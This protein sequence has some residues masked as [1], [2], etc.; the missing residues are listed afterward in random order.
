MKKLYLF[1]RIIKRSCSSFVEDN[2][3]KLSAALSY[4]TVFSIGPILLIIISLAGVFFGKEAVEGKIYHQIKG[5]VGS[6]AALQ[7]QNIIQ[8]ISQTG[9]VSGGAVIGG[10]ILILTAT[11]VFT[12]I[13][14]SIN[15]IWSVKAKPKKGWKKYLANRLISFSLVLSMGFLLM[16]ALIVNALIEVLSDK[17]L[18]LFPRYIVYLS[19]AVNV[20]II[21]V[22][23]SCLFTVIFK[24]L[25]DAKIKWK[26]ALI[27]AAFTAVLFLFGKFLI[28][29]YLS[30][31]HMEITYGTAASIVVILSWVYYSSMILYFGVEFTKAYVI[32][33]GNGIIP[34]ETAVFI[35]K[36]EVKEVPVTYLDT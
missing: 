15:Y 19:Y 3:F 9:N 33:A 24:V 6:D 35:L 25:P 1:W 14:E 32:E 21:L 8:N 2:A 4:Y 29:F 11:G 30:R 26:E 12:E 10:I 20:L 34:N 18:R 7:I 36:K 22:I 27:G 28:G 31:S 23:I 5:F 16:I 13:Q 17:L